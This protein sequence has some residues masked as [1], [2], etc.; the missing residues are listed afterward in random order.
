MYLQL[1]LISHIFFILFFLLFFCDL[2]FSALDFFMYLAYFF[3]FFEVF[4]GDLT[5]FYKDN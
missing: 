5:S 4:Y 1:F 3:Y 2:L